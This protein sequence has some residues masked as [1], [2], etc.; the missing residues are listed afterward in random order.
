MRRCPSCGRAYSELTA[1]CPVCH[2]SLAP[3]TNQGWNQNFTSN[4]YQSQQSFHN[5]AAPQQTYNPVPQQPVY[6]SAPQQ[7]VYNPA[8]Q[9]PAYNPAP[10]QPAAQ[11]KPDK[12]NWLWGLLGLVFPIGGLIAWA[13]LRK[14]HPASAKIAIYAA[15][16]GFLINIALNFL[17]V[18]SM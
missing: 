8:P 7:P 4:S 3:D 5:S 18:A 2:T 9:Q 6:N 17:A 11:Q 1:E 13:C 14:K 15:L 10:Q 16:A 12:G